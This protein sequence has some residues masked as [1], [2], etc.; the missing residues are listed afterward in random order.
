MIQEMKVKQT[1]TIH[2]LRRSGGADVA[3]AH[4][5]PSHLQSPA[6]Q[7]PPTVSL[8]AGAEETSAL[9]H[10]A[11]N[12]AN[13]GPLVVDASPQPAF[14]EEVLSEA[15]GDEAPASGGASGPCPAQAQQA[16]GTSTVTVVATA[17]SVFE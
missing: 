3:M 15:D 7:A 13:A 14:V 16:V 11:L 6:I 17:E 8:S 1:L 9:Q 12:S 4:Q 10:S 5:P 2:I